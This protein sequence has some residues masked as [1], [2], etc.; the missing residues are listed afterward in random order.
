MAQCAHGFAALLALQQV[1]DVGTFGL[2]HQLQQGAAL[3]LLGGGA[4]HVGQTGVGQT[5]AAHA[6]QDPDAL[7]G[8]VHQQAVARLGQGNDFVGVLDALDLGLKLLVL[9]F[10]LGARWQRNQPASPG[11]Q[12]GQQGRG[13]QQQGGPCP[14]QA[15]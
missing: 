13:A 2:G 12:P 8:R 1:D 15:C 14:A 10:Q 5:D 9:R 6:V 11:R 7:G 3:H 4:Q